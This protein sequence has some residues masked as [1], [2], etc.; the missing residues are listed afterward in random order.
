MSAECESRAQILLLQADK[1]NRTVI[2]SCVRLSALATYEVSVNPSVFLRPTASYALLTFSVYNNVLSGVWSVLEVNIGIMCICMPSFSRFLNQVAPSI[3]TGQS[4]TIGGGSSHAGP[5]GSRSSSVFGAPRFPL[6]RFSFGKKKKN[7]LDLSFWDATII[8]TV[9][10]TVEA[11]RAEDDHVRLVILKQGR[12]QVVRSGG[13]SR[14]SAT[15]GGSGSTNP[16]DWEKKAGDSE[17][18]VETGTGGVF[19]SRT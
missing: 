9:D 14:G 15:R 7:H 10:M 3:F 5:K 8:K 16:E 2:I 1:L 19:D 6:M 18:R 13:C 11:V 17:K 4:V 12:G